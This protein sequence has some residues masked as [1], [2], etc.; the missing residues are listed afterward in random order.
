MALAKPPPSEPGAGVD[1]VNMFQSSAATPFLN[2]STQNPQ[3]HHQAQHHGTHRQGQAHGI[4]ALAPVVQR[5]IE[6][7]VEPWL[8]TNK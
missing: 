4:G 6:F 7:H 5:L 3:Q 8:F 1:W 2:S